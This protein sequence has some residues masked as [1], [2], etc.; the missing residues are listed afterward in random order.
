M[1]PKVKVTRVKVTRSKSQ[2]KVASIE[3]KDCRSRSQGQGKSC[4]GSCLSPINTWAFSF[5]TV[6]GLRSHNRFSCIAMSMQSFDWYS[7]GK[8]PNGSYCI[9]QF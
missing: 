4:L 7:I 1:W 5:K 2:V 9:A 3:V 8:H 6:V